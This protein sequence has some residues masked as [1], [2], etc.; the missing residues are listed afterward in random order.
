MTP[1]VTSEAAVTATFCLW[2]S[3]ET[4]DAAYA[5]GYYFF[6]NHLSSAT[7]SRLERVFSKGE[8]R[9]AHKLLLAR[10]DPSY[11]GPVKLLH[12]ALYACSVT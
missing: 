12:V 11:F 1:T 9:I 7:S 10:C 4:T 2:W 3:V 5:S 8:L 6:C